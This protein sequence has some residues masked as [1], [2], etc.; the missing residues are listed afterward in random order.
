MES[1]KCCFESRDVNLIYINTVVKEM[2]IM[3]TEKGTKSEE[4]KLQ[5]KPEH[6]RVA[7]SNDHVNSE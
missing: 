5:M 2:E 6:V 3:K 4:R 1:R 7:S